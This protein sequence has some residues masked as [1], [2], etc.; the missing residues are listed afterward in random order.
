MYL[1]I[2]S[3]NDYLL[4]SNQKSAGKYISK[5]TNL[6]SEPVTIDAVVGQLPIIHEND[7]TRLNL[8]NGILG[9][10]IGIVIG[11]IVLITGGIMLIVDRRKPKATPI[12]DSRR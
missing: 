2:I 3:A 7:Q 12:E 9:G 10:I 6:G 4:Q 11:I 8:L 1:A 5:I